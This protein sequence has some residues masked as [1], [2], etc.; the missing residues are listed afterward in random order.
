MIDILTPLFFYFFF[1]KVRVSLKRFRYFFGY[2]LVWGSFFSR[3]YGLD[4]NGFEWL[5]DIL[6]F[7]HTFIPMSYNLVPVL[8]HV[9]VLV[10]DIND[11]NNDD[12]KGA[13]TGTQQL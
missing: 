10:D 6:C 11:D 12:K 5:I 4:R 8:F 13:T 2:G 9:T 7:K 3:I 1:A